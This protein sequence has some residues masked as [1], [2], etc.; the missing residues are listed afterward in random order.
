MEENQTKPNEDEVSAS[1]PEISTPIESR[2]FLEVVYQGLKISLGSSALRVDQLIE[3]ADELR[4]RF[5]NG[6]KRKEGPAY[7]G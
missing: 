3:V 5:T 6:T 7:T 1:I 4:N 2:E